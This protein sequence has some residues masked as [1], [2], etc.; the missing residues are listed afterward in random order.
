MEDL[1]L[2][3]ILKFLYPELLVLIVLGIFLGKML[4]NTP[5]MM[6]W[7]IPYILGIVNI[8]LAILIVG[9]TR[10]FI[11]LYL[12]LAAIQGFITA[13]LAV[14]VYQLYVQPTK[15]RL[16]EEKEKDLVVK[17]YKS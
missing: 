4:K 2:Q 10:G 9:F 3:I 17:E 6:D 13:A 1:T 16:E 7:L 5:K 8:I 15:K 14:Y 12:I 11:A